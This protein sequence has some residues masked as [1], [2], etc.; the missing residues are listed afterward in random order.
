MKVCRVEKTGDVAGEIGILCCRPQT[1]TAR[2]RSLCQL[3][4]LNRT[5][6]LSIVQ[7]N[8]GD[9]TTIVNNLLQVLTLCFIGKDILFVDLSVLIS[10]S[11][12]LVKYLK[13]QEDPVMMRVLREIEK[14]LAQGRLDLPLT[15]CFAVTR[16]DDLLLHQLLRRGLD[17][18]ESDS[19]GH[20]ALVRKELFL[21]SGS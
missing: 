4:R 19:N 9:A 18:N 8:V 21:C 2:T 11:V 12:V 20:T 7:S 1:F 13:E 10:C 6:F 15:L 17:P 16:G 14:M 5:T 3:L